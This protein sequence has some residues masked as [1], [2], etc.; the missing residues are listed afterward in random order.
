[1]KETEMSA[2]S[3]LY[4]SHKFEASTVVEMVGEE[5]LVNLPAWPHLFEVRLD[6]SF[7]GKKPFEGFHEAQHSSQKNEA[8]RALLS[9][10]L[11][12]FTS[13]LESEELRAQSGRRCPNT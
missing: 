5:K 12:N 7:C 1:M 10:G 13:R 2:Q 4:I 3:T 11:N 6:I 8:V 9:L